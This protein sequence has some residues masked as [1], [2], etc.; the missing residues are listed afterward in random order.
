MTHIKKKK[1]VL[2]T[3]ACWGCWDR[4]KKGSQEWLLEHNQPEMDMH[5]EMM[6]RLAA[7]QAA[8]SAA[9]DVSDDA[10]PP[11]GGGLRTKAKQKQPM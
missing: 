5:Q 8:S 6:A 9:V 10:A 4:A 2:I 3:D 7:Q 1:D 11:A